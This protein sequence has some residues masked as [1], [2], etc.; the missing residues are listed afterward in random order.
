MARILVVDDDKQIVRLVHSYLGQAGH[1]VLTANDGETALHIIR[2]E[3]PDLVVLDLMLP[4]RDGWDITRLVRGDPDLAGLP[5]IMLTAR[6]EDTDKIVGLELGADDYIAKPFN[7]R[8]VVARVR[9][10]L[11]RSTGEAPRA[12]V[13][14]VGELRLDLDRHELSCA[15]QAIELTPTEFDLLLILMKNPGHA[16]TRLEL[17]EKGLDYIYAG[18]ERTVDSHIKNLRKKINLDPDSPA[19][20]E[21]VY[22]IGYRLRGE[23]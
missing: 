7:P 6:V 22:G 3:K 2:R 8:E 13:L 4:D 1:Q 18:M 14:Q 21:T 19:Y 23:P 15:G 5:I 10:V 17:I 20:I 9:A 11:R 16:F 12:H